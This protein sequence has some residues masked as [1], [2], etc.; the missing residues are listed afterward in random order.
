MWPSELLLNIKL[1]IIFSITQGRRDI[2]IFGEWRFILS[3]DNAYNSFLEI[4]GYCNAVVKITEIQSTF[5]ITY[6]S[7]FVFF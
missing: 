5:S 6:I 4:N 1:A 3:S 2:R 7:S